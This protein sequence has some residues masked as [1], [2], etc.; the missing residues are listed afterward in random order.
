MPDVDLEA[1]RRPQ[2]LPDGGRRPEA[3]LPRRPASGAVEVTM[4]GRRED[5][6]LLATISAVPMP[7]E[8]ELLED[9]ERAVHRGRD[10]GEVARA[11]LLHQLGSSD[12]TIG[13]G[14]HLDHGAALRRPAQAAAAEPR[15][16][17]IPGS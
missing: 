14:E 2:R 1:V 5:V 9:V 6:E 16:D 12:V 4:L 11:A 15:S 3:D 7:D 8:P 17:A 13:L 10:R